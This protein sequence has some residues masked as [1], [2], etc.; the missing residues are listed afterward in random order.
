MTDKDL[1]ENVV[2]IVVAVAFAVSFDRCLRSKTA[3]AR[4]IIEF[5]DDQKTLLY[6][7]SVLS[8]FVRNE[9][10]NKPRIVVNLP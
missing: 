10:I 1:G 3:D 5:M 4:R 9:S 7:S 6:L 2:F 8:A